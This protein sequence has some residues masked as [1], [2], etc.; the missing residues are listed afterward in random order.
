MKKK[1]KKDSVSWGSELKKLHARLRPTSCERSILTGAA[2]VDPN[3]QKVTSPSMVVIGHGGLLE[4]AGQPDLN[5]S[6]SLLNHGYNPWDLSGHLVL[7]AF[8][9]AHVHLG[10]KFSKKT[11][12]GFFSVEK[13]LD[14]L[15]KAIKTGIGLLRD[16]GNPGF[17]LLDLK[18]HLAEVGGLRLMACGLPITTSKG[19]M[20]SLGLAAQ[21]KTALKRAVAYLAGHGVDFIKIC[22]TGGKL[23]PG[24]YP[25]L[26]QYTAAE[27]KAVVNSAATHGLGLAA[28]A[29]GTAGVQIC[30]E[31]GVQW[32]EH[33]SFMKP[34]GGYELDETLLEKM[35]AGNISLGF[36]LTK[37]KWNASAE[38][39]KAM[40]QGREVMPYS[41]F[42]RLLGA[43]KKAG[44]NFTIASDGEIPG[45]PFGCL[46]KI[47]WAAKEIYQI[48]VWE[49]LKA[50]TTTPAGI[51]RDKGSTYARGRR[52]ELAAVRGGLERLFK[53][54]FE[55]EHLFMG[56]SVF[57]PRKMKYWP[58]AS[59]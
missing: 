45:S 44:V 16:C 26:A 56:K 40:D 3:T 27:M 42:K 10:M 41:Y 46:G 11:G 13:A 20:H 14:D 47:L 55:V 15:Q 6:Q 51:W 31:A 59:P 30:V 1:S 58:E 9:D 22:A 2:L 37:F 48:P 33:C 19:H 28:H 32:V 25:A 49:I 38:E 21:G 17:F 12:H 4:Y 57:S 7:P 35:A 43:A 50:V 18:K 24:S 23:T 53:D 34:G 54:D 8:A 36:T 5:L 29:H 52:A 39:I